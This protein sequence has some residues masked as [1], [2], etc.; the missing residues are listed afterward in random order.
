MA[1]GPLK[2][3]KL[4]GKIGPTK[5]YFRAEQRMNLLLNDYRLYKF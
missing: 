2:I 3:I 4:D 1:T 5:V